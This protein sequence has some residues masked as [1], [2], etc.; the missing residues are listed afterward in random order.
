MAK[1]YVTLA[2]KQEEGDVPPL[3]TELKLFSECLAISDGGWRENLVEYVCD[4]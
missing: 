2:Q 3:C 4:V 1:R